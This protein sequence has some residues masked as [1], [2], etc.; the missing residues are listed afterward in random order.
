MNDDEIMSN[1]TKKKISIKN[2]LNTTG[3]LK[4]IKKNIYN[5]LIYYWDIPNGFDLI[6]ALFDSCYKNLD[7]IENED[8]KQQII[9]RLRD[10]F[11]EIEGSRM[12]IPEPLLNNPVPFDAESSIRLHKEYHQRHK[13]KNKK[14]DRLILNTTIT[15]EITNY[16]SLPIALE[17][18][19][20][21]TWWQSQLQMFPNLSKIVQKYLAI[22]TDFLI[23]EIL[24]LPFSK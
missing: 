22:P 12:P 17:T 10:E 2:P 21:L 24:L 16:L 13:M 4:E 19:N 14:G 23:P 18:E 6:A 9:Q 5:A 8:E 15:D 7:F 1:I 20:P 3:I 11:N